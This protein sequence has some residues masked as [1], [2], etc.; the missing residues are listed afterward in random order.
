MSWVIYDEPGV[1]MSNRAWMSE[2]NRI[3]TWFLQSSRYRRVNALFCL[4]A[5][6]LMDI[7]A[8]TILTFQALILNR[9][10]ARIYRIRRN[11]FGSSPSYFTHRLG[12]VKTGLPSKELVDSYEKKL[13]EWHESFF[14]ERPAEK[15]QEPEVSDTD[16]ILVSVRKRP[17]DYVGAD[18]SLSAK[19]VVAKHECSYQ[20]A[21]KVKAIV[22]DEGSKEP[23]A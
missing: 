6:A 16:K 18:G 3:V 2:A 21:Y 14:K 12:T 7:A 1:T 4:P 15:P 20:T 22:E 23:S 17:Q 10:V 8:R 11:Q 9:G 19:K 13:R 5:L